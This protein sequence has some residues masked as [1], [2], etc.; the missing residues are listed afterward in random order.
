MRQ[1]IAPVIY[2]ACPIDRVEGAKKR[3]LTDMR[4]DCRVSL[5]SFGFIFFDPTAAWN[6]PTAVRLASGPLPTA[7]GSVDFAAVD[8][9]DGL[10]AL[11]PDGYA[12]YGVPMEVERALGRGI[13]TVIVGGNAA[14]RS[15]LFAE[16]CP[17]YGLNQIDLAVRHLRSKLEQIFQTNMEALPNLR[18]PPDVPAL[19]VIGEGQTPT[20]TY[21]DDCGMDLY[22]Y[23]SPQ[24]PQNVVVYPGNFLDIDCGVSIELPPGVWGLI[25]GRSSAI[26]KKNLLIVNGI[27]DT[28]YRG[29]LFMPVLNVGKTPQP[30]QHGERIGQLILMQNVTLG[31][32]IRRVDF[33]SPSERG[34]KGRGSSGA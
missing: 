19:K 33:L 23:V 22:T 7:L 28:G 11:L 10:L 6:V 27:I 3:E 32:D 34:E 21:P 18:T 2:L 17:V 12:T 24:P 30:I 26:R 1:A 9:A 20:R 13:P 14:H 29:R 4:D 5:D 16:R 31:Y 25:T 8:S 15:P